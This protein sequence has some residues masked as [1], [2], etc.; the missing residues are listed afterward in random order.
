MRVYFEGLPIEGGV[1]LTPEQMAAWASGEHAE[2]YEDYIEMGLLDPETG[3]LIDIPEWMVDG[4]PNNGPFDFLLN[5][6]QAHWGW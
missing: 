6:S 3:I 5:P 4:D 2:E 1:T